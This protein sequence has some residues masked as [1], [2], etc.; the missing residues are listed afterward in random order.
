[1]S[2]YRTTSIPTI[3]IIIIV[4]ICYL[5]ISENTGFINQW[6]IGVTMYDCLFVLFVSFKPI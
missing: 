4:I 1:M 5:F 6:Q 3:I 2:I